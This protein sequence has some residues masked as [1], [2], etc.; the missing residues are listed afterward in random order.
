MGDG[1]A[2]SPA[3]LRRRDNHGNR[4]QSTSRARHAVSSID[5]L[6]P[7]WADRA[8][9]RGRL[10]RSFAAVRG[11]LPRGDGLDAEAFRQRH[12]LLCWVLA[13]HV[14]S[15][16][17]FGVWQG[18][19]AAH[20]ALEVVTPAACLLFARLARNRRVAAFFVTAGLVFCSSVLVHLSGGTIEA[21][22]HFFILIGLIALYQDWVP[23]T[24]NV[25]FT[26]LSHGLGST[27]AANLMYNHGAAQDRPWSWAVIHGLA[28]LAACVGVIVFWRN[29]ELEQQRS[30]ALASELV[31]AELSA[32]QVEADRR[33]SV[34]EL[35][36]NL[37][38]RNQSLLDRQLKLIAELE[39][40]ER[41]PE[42]LSELFRLDHLA[43]RIRRNAESLLVLS[44]DE[45]LR[46]WGRPMPL[47]EVVRAAAAEV[48]DFQR[49]EVLVNGYLEVEG[50]VVADLAHLLAELIENATAFSPPAAP[51]RVRS[52]VAYDA[53]S[54][55]VLSVEDT[56][57]G[58]PD[59]AL[60]AANVLL[61]EPP[62]VDVRRSTLGLH[63]VSRLANRYGCQVRLV[64]TPGGGVTALVTLPNDIVSERRREAPV[65]AGVAPVGFGASPAAVGDDRLPVPRLWSDGWHL[66][67][68][69]DTTPEQGAPAQTPLTAEPVPVAPARRV[70]ST[71]GTTA[72]GL[73][74]RVPG[75]ALAEG[76]RQADETPP[77]PGGPASVTWVPTGRDRDRMRSMLSRFQTG[78]RV[79]RA[80]SET[81]TE[82]GW[83]DGS[84]ADP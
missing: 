32:V 30:S 48:E 1:L 75:V 25:V 40:R 64:P 26:V 68:P 4:R 9:K 79:A 56:G 23:F 2:G 17:A 19:G 37:A 35:F 33:Q 38:R 6:T 54:S 12:L 53:R 81:P 66:T 59:D 58:M 69:D 28:V 50:R 84:E 73:T 10:S 14:P 24:W 44:G 27:I 61:S 65:T 82:A 3:G 15:L 83:P 36:V 72:Q 29:T 47:A 70:A 21:H 7:D 39:Q 43:T 31:A 16:F 80:A 42:A 22:F 67:P 18:Y 8:T 78:Q 11:Y 46:Q 45:P 49:V 20:S 62:E 71:S 55:F 57:I 34:S 5:Q 74:R 51:V 60:Q 63:V 52:H 41:S 76:L 13:L 77:G